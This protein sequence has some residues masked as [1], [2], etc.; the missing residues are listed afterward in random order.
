MTFNFKTHWR[1]TTALCIASAITLAT[2]AYAANGGLSNWDMRSHPSGKNNQGNNNQGNNNGNNNNNNNKGPGNTASPIKHVIVLIGEN[3]GL[4]HTFGVYKPKG[5]GE[6]ISNLLSKGIVNEDGTPGPNFGLAQQF[7]VAQQPSYYIGAPAISKSAYNA[8]T[9]MPQPNT[10]GAPSVQSAT[11][12]P[13]QNVAEASVEKDMDPANLDI[14]TTGATGL[15]AGALD[16][17]IPGAGH[18]TGPFPLQGASITDDDYTGDTTHRFYQ[19][20]QQNDCSVANA[21][22]SNTSGCLNDL[23]PFVMVTYAKNN[24][25]GSSMGFYNTEQGEAPILK[26]LADRFTLGDNFHQ[27]FHGGTGANHVMLGTPA[28]GATATAIPPRR[29][30]AWSRTRIRS[31]APSMPTRLTAI[32]APAPT[33]ASPVSGRS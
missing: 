16:I 21:T 9:L 24:S 26:Q 20:W 6:T 4:D 28:S 29:P 25:Q 32:S 1:T 23:F 17:R 5:K 33:S 15:P 18:L 14:L 19:D 31:R 2:T 22:K 13:F 11:S 27:S 7:Q 3:R 8:M 10:N 30:P 12:P